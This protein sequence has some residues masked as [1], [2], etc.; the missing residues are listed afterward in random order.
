[1]VGA[2]KSH[3]DVQLVGDKPS[4]RMIFSRRADFNQA[5]ID[6]DLEAIR[7]VLGEH[8]VLVP[9]D[10]AQLI[11]GRDA[12]LEAWQTIFSS[13]EDVMYQRSPAR[14]E[15]AEDG[16]LAAETGR[17]K[18]GWTSEGF[19]IRYTG[20]YFAKWRHTDDGWEIEAETFVTMKCTGAGL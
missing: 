19:Q 16:H 8:S 9:G 2:R 5:L 1:M 4:A 20:R 15:V 11:V 14:I 7:A 12:Q 6:R 10:E 18:G 13:T 17:W 3:G